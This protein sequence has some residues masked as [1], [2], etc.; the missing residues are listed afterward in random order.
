MQERNRDPDIENR[1]VDTGVIGERKVGDEMSWEI[2]TDIYTLPCVK[3]IAS[4]NLLY[5]ARS[6]VRAL[7][8]DGER[9][10][11]ELIHFRN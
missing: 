4:G 11:I 9:G 8:W 3:W 6:S 5:R 10:N 2:G 1:C 7:W